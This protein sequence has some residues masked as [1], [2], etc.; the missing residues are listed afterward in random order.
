MSI[1]EVFSKNPQIIEPFELF[2]R[3]HLAALAVIVVFI[4]AMTI[5]ASKYESIRKSY[6]W[7]MLIII[8]LQEITYKIWD[9]LIG[10]TRLSI[11]F[12]MH[13]CSAAI[14]IIVILLVRF[15]QTLFEVLYFW[16]LGGAVQA[17]IT[18]DITYS[19]FPHF[20]FFQ[21]FFSHGMI[22][23]AVFYFIFAE[24]KR[25]RKGALLRTILI[26]NAY[27]VIV[28]IVNYIAGTNYLF[29]NRKPDTASLIDSLGPWPVYLIWL[30]VIMIAVFSILYLV[31]FIG[32]MKRDREVLAC[33]ES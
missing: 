4:T 7:F 33:Q 17:L 25:L 9:G 27:A 16:G 14:I 22:I 24:G 23:A 31:P 26:T 11:V 8:P 12:S 18:P 10:G 3:Q 19:G 21:V 5:L 2:S 29:I 1:S 28:F 6:K 13:L 32:R 30:E 15:D 20:R